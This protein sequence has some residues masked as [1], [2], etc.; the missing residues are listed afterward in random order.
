VTVSGKRRRIVFRTINTGRILM[1]VT[2][3]PEFER[4]VNE[5]LQA[6]EYRSAADVLNAAMELFK[7]REEDRAVLRGVVAGEA[8]PIDGRFDARLATLLEEAEEGGE[9]TGMTAQDWD[10]IER[11]ALAI[12]RSGKTA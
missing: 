9:A 12:L 5:K 10:D 2:L 1:N 11:E 4:L 3:A 6:G 8:L 7:E